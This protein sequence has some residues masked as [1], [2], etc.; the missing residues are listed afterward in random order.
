MDQVSTA[1]A[2]TAAVAAI[3]RSLSAAWVQ[4]YRI[5]EEA[6]AERVRHLPPGSR[7]WDFG[8]GALLIE[9]ADDPGR[10]ERADGA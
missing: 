3:I 2:I 9:V 8:D 1:A 7:L 10:G 6:R 5:R 4:R